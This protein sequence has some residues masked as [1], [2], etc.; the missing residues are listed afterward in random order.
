MPIT[1]TARH[2]E[3]SDELKQRA[4]AVLE[5]LE[6]LASR[7]LE[8]TLVFDV[9]PTSATAEIRMKGGKGEPLVATGEAK[10]HRSALDRAEE[11]IRRQ[12]EKEAGSHRARGARDAV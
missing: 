4:Q 1:I 6:S 12:L 11:K 8:G 5:R 9:A 10:D 2:C 3:I 7:P